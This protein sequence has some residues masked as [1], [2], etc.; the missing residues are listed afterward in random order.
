MQFKVNKL[1]LASALGVASGM[2]VLSPFNAAASTHAGVLNGSSHDMGSHSLRVG[3]V[4]KK[5][6]PIFSA[7]R[8]AGLAN[9]SFT[10]VTYERGKRSILSGRV[11]SQSNFEITQPGESIF[12]VGGKGYKV[13]GGKPQS[14]NIKSPFLYISQTDQY[15]WAK[16]LLSK[17][18]TKGTSVKETGTCLADGLKGNKYTIVQKA[19]PASPTACIDAKSGVLL[20]YNSNIHTPRKQAFV[21]FSFTVTSVGNVKPISLPIIHT[22][23]ATTTTLPKILHYIPSSFPA[24]LPKPP[25]N[26]SGAYTKGTPN[27]IWIII[28]APQNTADVTRYITSLEHLGFKPYGEHYTNYTTTL[29]NAK[30]QITVSYETLGPSVVEMTT[31]LA[32]LKG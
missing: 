9:Y 11:Y 8:L 28:T 15:A 21:D 30:Y 26:L 29:R 23:K 10:S 1:I 12:Y 19:V 5:A 31:S 32:L 22:A 14:F 7:A 13:T 6:A 18:D 2:M 25:G 3:H 17:V 27:Y 4:T 20:W 16:V 24:S